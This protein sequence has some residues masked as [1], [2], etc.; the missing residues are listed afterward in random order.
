MTAELPREAAN[1]MLASTAT[2]LIKRD[3]NDLCN[4]AAT[5]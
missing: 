2:Q 3:F 5:M 4:H 1:R